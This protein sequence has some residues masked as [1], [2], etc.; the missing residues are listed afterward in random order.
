MEY[1]CNVCNKKYSS[2]QSLWIHNKKFHIVDVVSNSTKEEL[3]SID[4][5]VVEKKK[6]ICLFCNRIFND[7]S[8]KAK[9]QHICK[10]KVNIIDENNKLKN[11][12]E[13]LKNNKK[14]TI[15]NNNITNNINN[16]KIIN[17]IIK[18]TVGCE[19]L[20]KLSKKDKKIIL[21]SGYNSL[22]TLIDLLNLN[23]NYPEFNNLKITN[24]NS[25]YAKTYNKELKNYETVNKK[26][27]IEDLIGY[28]TA[29]LK[30]IYDEYNN[31][32]I[33]HT[34]V[35]KLIEKINNHPSEKY[36]KNMYEEIT[37]LIYNKSKNFE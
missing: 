4:K 28:R 19:D 37:L 32:T 2:Y 11:E 10:I 35:L 20:S 18:V 33:M 1:I 12:N 5:V 25:K 21:S 27:L 16:G 9:H 34:Y 15:N 13:K 3:Y 8:N 24:M 31:D 29:N 36:K 26:Y 23:Q 14:I 17:N 6:Y 22:I 30:E 7:R